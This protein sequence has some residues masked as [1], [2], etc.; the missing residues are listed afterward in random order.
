MQRKVTDLMGLVMDINTSCEMSVHM[1]YRA[2]G[3]IKVI[4]P[5]KNE[6]LLVNIHAKDSDKRIESIEH[7]LLDILVERGIA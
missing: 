3:V 7:R 6:R 5:E 1:E 4:I 2:I